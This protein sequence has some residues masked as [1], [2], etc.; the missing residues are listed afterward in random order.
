LWLRVGPTPARLC[1]NLGDVD[2]PN[3]GWNDE[4]RAQR[5]R[6]SGSDGLSPTAAAR[7]KR[8]LRGDHP[9]GDRRHQVVTEANGRLVLAGRLD[10][11]AELDLA[12]VDRAESGGGDRVRDIRGLDGAEQP[13][14][15]SG[16]DREVTGVA[17]SF[18]L[19]SWASSMVACSRAARAALICSICFSPPRVQ[20]T[21]Q[22]CGMR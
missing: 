4:N 9:D 1:T 17:W 16:L 18:D 13:T 6:R 12:L 11:S 3:G 15:L 8:L 20:T 5:Q 19:R 21:A 2:P 14:T 22:P 7:A 10:R